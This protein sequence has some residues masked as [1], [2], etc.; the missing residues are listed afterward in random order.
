MPSQGRI[1]ANPVRAYTH[2]HTQTHAHTNHYF[3]KPKGLS[4]SYQCYM[5]GITHSLTLLLLKRETVDYVLLQ[6]FQTALINML[7]GYKS[8]QSG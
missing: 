2:S 6:V 3:T 5:R 8:S 1:I 4:C 7:S